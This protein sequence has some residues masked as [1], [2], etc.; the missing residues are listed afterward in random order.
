MPPDT[1]EAMLG[2]DEGLLMTCL[3]Y[4]QEI[5]YRTTVLSIV[6]TSGGTERFHDDM[7]EALNM[8]SQ[9]SPQLDLVAE[10]Y[11]WVATWK[12]V[13]DMVSL[14]CGEDL[15]WWAVETLGH[16]W[17]ENTEWEMAL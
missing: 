10:I 11:F 3:Q 17:L 5:W 14:E 8:I 9:H 15:L 4:I 2:V 7:I 16:R 12:D 13:N 1:A 6:T